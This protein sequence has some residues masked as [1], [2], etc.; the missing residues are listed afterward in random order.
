MKSNVCSFWGHR[1]IEMTEDLKQKIKGIIEDMIVNNNVRT[2]LFGSR[3]EFDNLCHLLVTELKEKYPNIKRKAYTCKS[4]TC[5]LESERQK[6]EGIYARFKREKVQL[7]GVEE[8]VEY[9]TKYIAGK[10]SYIERNKAMIDDSDYCIFYYDKN[11]KPPQRKYSKRNVCYYQPQSGTAIAY[12][13]AER[14]GKIV[15]NV[16]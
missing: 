3:S 5:T 4:E 8:S 9:K 16:F 2:F 14:K 13:Y 6:W 10:A 15:L 7:L 1:K 11:Y 12:A